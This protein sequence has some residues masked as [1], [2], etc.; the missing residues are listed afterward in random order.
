[1]HRNLNSQDGIPETKNQWKDSNPKFKG[2]SQELNQ[3]QKNEGMN[4]T[5]ETL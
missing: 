5:E 4:F 2:D 3:S 1:M